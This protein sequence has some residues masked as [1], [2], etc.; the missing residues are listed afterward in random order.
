[1]LTFV[2][3]SLFPLLTILFGFDALTP[4]GIE[5]WDGKTAPRHAAVAIGVSTIVASVGV[6]A[7]LFSYFV[8][9][10]RLL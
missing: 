4:E 9:Q 8:L 2:I 3:C 1:M 7:L 10:I 5:I 6:M